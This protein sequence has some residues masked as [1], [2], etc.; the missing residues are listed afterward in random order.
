MIFLYLLIIETVV[1]FGAFCKDFN[2]DSMFIKIWG[3]AT[4][5]YLVAVIF[6]FDK[7]Y[8]AAYKDISKSIIE[9]D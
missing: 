7:L 2:Q 1:L 3:I 5:I 9:E 4:L 8:T 6:N